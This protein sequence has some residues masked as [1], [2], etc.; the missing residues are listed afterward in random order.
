MT[1]YIVLC[2]ALELPY[3]TIFTVIQHFPY[4]MG[5]LGL[6]AVLG[7]CGRERLIAG[8][9]YTNDD[10]DEWIQLRD[11]QIDLSQEIRVDVLGLIPWNAEHCFN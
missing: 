10:G 9:Y 3:G 7:V 2:H 6:F 4:R 11:L 5:A 1:K 8:R